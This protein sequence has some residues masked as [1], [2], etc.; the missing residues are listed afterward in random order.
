MK[1]VTRL[2]PDYSAAERAVADLE[3]AGPYRDVSLISKSPEKGRQLD[4]EATDQDREDAIDPANPPAETAVIGA[5]MGASLGGGVGLLAGLGLLAIPGVGPVIAAGWL[6]SAAVG[7][8]GGAVLGGTGGGLLG[9]LMDG[10]ETEP[11]ARALVAGLGRGA[12]LV[13]V[14]TDPARA[15]AV[16]SIL[17]GRGGV[18]P[19][20]DR[21]TLDDESNA[22]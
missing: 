18:I 8:G 14:R 1:T 6:A 4:V 19:P 13:S 2:F 7:A 3:A 15:D 20:R 11:D 22:G 12:A 21:Q 9:A 16:A 17:E 5:G 10:G